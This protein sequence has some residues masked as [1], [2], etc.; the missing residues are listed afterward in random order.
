MLAEAIHRAPWRPTSGW[1]IG[2]ALVCAAPIVLLLRGAMPD[3]APFFFGLPLLICLRYRSRRLLWLLAAA[4]VALAGY[5]AFFPFAS[6]RRDAVPLQWTIPIA[7]ILVMAG[8]VHLILR[9]LERLQ[10]AHDESAARA[11]ESTRRNAELQSQLEKLA[12]KNRELERQ[13]EGLPQQTKELKTLSR[14]LEQ[15]RTAN[16]NLDRIVVERTAE[17]REIINELEQFSYTITH[18]LRA[19]LRAM[20]GYAEMLIE[21]AGRSLG[22]RAEKYAR[23]ISKSAVRMDQLIADALSYSEALRQTLELGP[24]D[25]EIL[26]REMIDADPEF[27]LPRAQ[28]DIVGPLPPVI[29]N[30]AGLTQC[31]SNLLNNAVKFVPEGVVP[32]VTI[33][34][35]KRNGSVRL[36]FE[37]NGIGIASEMLPKLFVM[38]QRLNRKYEGTGIGLALVKKVAERMRGSVGVESELGRG[39]RFWTEFEAV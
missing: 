21:E 14:E 35:E 39:S 25:P 27:Q 10:R 16:L 38:F 13:A 32:E 3:W 8:T 26:L 36:W 31:F 15:L 23:C 11:E 2:L 22:E 29:A 37:D 1:S 24:L 33:R 19:P 4:Y 12:T 28:I 20:N 7:N 30:I 9:F 34:A 5:W 18:N 6:P 17:L